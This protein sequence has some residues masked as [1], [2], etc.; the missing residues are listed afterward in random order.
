M[1]YINTKHSNKTIASFCH[2][3]WDSYVHNTQLHIKRKIIVLFV[4]NIPGKIRFNKR[5]NNGGQFKHKVILLLYSFKFIYVRRIKPSQYRSSGTAMLECIALKN[6]YVC[7]VHVFVHVQSI[8]S[9][10]YIIC[11]IPT[12]KFGYAGYVCCQPLIHTIV[13]KGVL[14]VCV[15]ANMNKQQENALVH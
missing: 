4:I 12:Y 5:C 10:F 1:Y 13:W 14:C 9:L 3:I 8:Q 6:G 11:T 15:C 2:I 7:I